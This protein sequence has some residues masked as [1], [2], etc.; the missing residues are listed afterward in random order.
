MHIRYNANK[1]VFTLLDQVINKRCGSLTGFTLV[2][3]M[4][5]IVIVGI[6]AGLALPRFTITLE[7]MKMTEGMKILNTLRNAQELFN[8]ENGG[9][10]SNINNLDVT[11][12]PPDNF[13]DPNVFDTPDPLAS[14]RREIAVAAYDYTLTIDIDGTIK[15]VPPETPANIC[16]R[17][18]CTGGAGNNECN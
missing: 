18:A 1:R 9:Y 8:V 12:P 4:I 5:T 13:E 6:L 17:L 11:I 10:T 7:R 14:I 2:E 15:C 16:T 3:I